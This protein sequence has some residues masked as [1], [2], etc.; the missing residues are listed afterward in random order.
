[1]QI[2]FR[3]NPE[4]VEKRLQPV[5]Y[6]RHPALKGNTWFLSELRHG[7]MERFGRFCQIRDN[8]W[9]GCCITVLE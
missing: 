6:E 5:M 7:K 4:G 8:R 1:M 9:V 2:D 3:S